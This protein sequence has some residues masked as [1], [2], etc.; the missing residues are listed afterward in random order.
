MEKYLVRLT[1]NIKSLQ[2]GLKYGFH[3]VDNHRKR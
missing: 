2:G 1:T 3:I